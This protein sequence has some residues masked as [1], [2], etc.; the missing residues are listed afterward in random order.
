MS[1]STSAAGLP[2]PRAG[3]AGGRPA[4]VVTTSG[5]AVANLH[6][7]V[8]EAHHGE[9]PLIV[10]Q[11]RPAGGAAGHRRQPDDH[12]DGDFRRQPGSRPTF[13][14]REVRP[15]RTPPGAAPSPGPSRRPRGHR[16]ATRAGPP[17][18][19]FRDPLAPACP[20]DPPGRAAGP[21]PSRAGPAGSRGCGAAA[22]PRRRPAAALRPSPTWHAPSSSSATCAGLARRRRC[23]GPGRGYPV[24]AEPFGSLGRRAA[25]CARAAAARPR[26]GS[27][28]TP[29]SVCSSSDAHSLPPGGAVLR[30]PGVAVEAVTGGA[31]GR[32]VARRVC[33]HPW[34][35]L[36]DPGGPRGCAATLALGR[37]LGPSAGP[38]AEAVP[39][40][41]SRGRAASPWRRRWPGRSRPGPCSSSARPTRSA[42][43]TSPWAPRPPPTRGRR[44]GR[45]PWPRRD[46]RSGVHRGGCRSG[47]A[48]R[49]AYALLGDLTFLHDA[50]GL[51]IGPDE[52]RPD[53]T[54]VV[55]NDDGG[56]IFATLEHGAPERADR[57]ERI[58]GTPTGTTSPGCA[59]PTASPISPVRA[60]RWPRPS[61]R[62]PTGCASSR[63]GSTAPPIAPRTRPW[64]SWP[65]TPYRRVVLTARVVGPARRPCRRT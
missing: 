59:A 25:P 43:S 35:A 28:P 22:P 48:R 36:S 61:P 41:A 18:V 51:T 13:P 24:V 1:G 62:S 29:R 8:L 21:R 5:T 7:A 10:R 26:A 14:R 49:P 57:F 44:R 33:V 17:N 54:I 27:T 63:S 30:H 46:R 47:P 32:P 45:Q 15:A 39:P 60:V 12:P 3:P 4:A 56:G 23:A 20:A 52:P 38:L 50:N 55:L 11:R 64:R 16:P 6:P 2:R 40:R 53:L 9:V 19:A 31:V 42:T 37:R 34:S 65:R 58:F